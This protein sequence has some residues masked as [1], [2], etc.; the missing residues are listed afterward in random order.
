MR[1]VT[2][3][4]ESIAAAI[5]SIS[6][7]TGRLMWP[8]VVAL[9]GIVV[10]EVLL[11]YAFNR[12][13]IWAFDVEYMVGSFFWMIG[14]AYCLKH[15]GHVRVDFLYSRLSVR[16]QAIIDV[17]FAVTMFFPVFGLLVWKMVPWVVFSWASDE[18]S[19]LG[20][21]YPVMYPWKT[22]IL[23]AFALLLLQG[24]AEFIRSLFTAVRG[25]TA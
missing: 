12:P 9:T 8:L 3:F 5:D 7:W 19:L 11:R 25:G 18:R 13:T 1:S 24:V 16:W 17:V 23:V 20:F 6:E 14:L 21:W 4:L 2:G 10:Y 22:G 15:G